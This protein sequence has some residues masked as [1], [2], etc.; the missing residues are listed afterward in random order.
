MQTKNPSALRQR[1]FCL[2]CVFDGLGFADDVDLDLSGIFEL[3]LD[4]LGKIMR[5][6]DHVV[7]AD[8][9]GLDHDA[10][11]AAGLNGVGLFDAREGAG[12]LFELFEPADVVLDVFTARTG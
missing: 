1:D 3:G 10:D 7:L 11:L 9:F 8:L 2:L 4:L 6:Q 12:E 5:K